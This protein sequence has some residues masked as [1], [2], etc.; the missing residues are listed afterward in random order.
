MTLTMSPRI[1]N[2][3]PLVNNE[4]VWERLSAS[5]EFIEAYKRALLQ[6]IAEYDAKYGEILP[7]QTTA[8]GQLDIPPRPPSLLQRI[9]AKLWWLGGAKQ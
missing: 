5:R 7:K 8:V 9:A 3:P 6:R 2:I 4:I 1:D